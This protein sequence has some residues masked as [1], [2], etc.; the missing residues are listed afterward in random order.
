MNEAK[1][2]GLLKKKIQLKHMQYSTEKSYSSW[3]KRYMRF[4][5]ALP[6][7]LSSEEKLERW[8][9]D[10]SGRVAASTQNQAFNAVLFFYRDCLGQNLEGIDALRAKRRKVEKFCPSVE[11]T[12]R[13]LDAV[14]DTEAYPTRLIIHLLYGCGLRVSE[15]LNLRVRDVRIDA[16]QLVIR[17][18]KH[19]NDRVVHL[20][21][22]L[23]NDLHMQLA[24]AELMH[25]RDRM[26]DLPVQLPGALGKKYPYAQ[27]SWP[28]YFVFPLQN[29]CKHPRTK[30][31]VRYRCLETT[32]QRAMRS[33]AGRVGLDG[34][35]PHTLRHAYATHCLNAG[36]NIRNIQDALGH[37]SLET[38]MGY[39]HAGAECVPS[40]LVSLS[41]R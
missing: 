7:G 17:D 41:Y 31:M 13:V 2:I 24:K 19:G 26:D 28:W 18:P 8:L 20:P 9:S 3:L 38:T 40:P 12:R 37:R 34:I 39:T 16:R 14:T 30:K 4:I 10:M 33:A 32:V 11:E 5:R 35:T 1:A 21:E 25:K 6:A 22:P 15:P 29:P 36:S 27:F 23:V